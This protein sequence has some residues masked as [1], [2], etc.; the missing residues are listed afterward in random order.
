MRPS[1]PR[2]RLCT[3][4]PRAPLMPY[5]EEVRWKNGSAS[6]PSSCLSMFSFDGSVSRYAVGFLRLG[7]L[8]FLGFTILD[9]TKVY[10]SVALASLR[11]SCVAIS[12]MSAGLAVFLASAM[13]AVIS[14]T[15]DASA[16]SGAP[17]RSTAPALAPSS[18]SSSSAGSSTFAPGRSI[19][20]R[21]RSCCISSASTRAAMIREPASS[22]IAP[23]WKI[24]MVPPV[25][26]RSMSRIIRS[27]SSML[28]AFRKAFFLFT[29]LSMK[30]FIASP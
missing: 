17:S 9:W 3:I 13:S 16:H 19:M 14:S 10:S 18:S 22:I 8:G 11:L 26:L 25:E 20:R 27:M 6:A 12:C 21:S 1:A 2:S 24:S 29:L 5:R 30:R 23:F 15:T 28:Y 4:R 7:F